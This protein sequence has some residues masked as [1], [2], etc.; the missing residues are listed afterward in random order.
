MFNILTTDVFDE[1]LA[2]LKNSKAKATIT[3]RIMRAMQGNFGD[4][5]FLRESLWEMRIDTG[6]GYRVYY[7]QRGKVIYLLLCGGD[8]SSQRQD[9]ERAITM[10]S[11]LEQSK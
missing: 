8:K 9:I 6:K 2:N 3:K 5:K 11:Q 1:W 10:I 7:N 4:H